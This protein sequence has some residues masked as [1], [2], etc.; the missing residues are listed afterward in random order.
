[1]ADPIVCDDVPFSRDIC[2]YDSTQIYCMLPVFTILHV[3]SNAQIY[4]RG[5]GNSRLYICNKIKIYCNLKVSSNA[6]VNGYDL[7]YNCVEILKNSK[8]YINVFVCFYIKVHEKEKVYGYLEVYH[9]AD[10]CNEKEI[11][12]GSCILHNI[13]KVNKNDTREAFAERIGLLALFEIICGFAFCLNQYDASNWYKGMDL[14]SFM[15]LS[16]IIF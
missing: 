6:R 14:G 15:R 3:C 5:T 4:G 9:C 11:W 8:I 16:C 2:V 7:V 13:K 1:M 12:I 10:F